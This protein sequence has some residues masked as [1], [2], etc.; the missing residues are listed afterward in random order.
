LSGIAACFPSVG[1]QWPDAA[2]LS[3]C[4]CSPPDGGSA[5]DEEVG[6]VPVQGTA[7]IVEAQRDDSL[8]AKSKFDQQAQIDAIQNMVDTL[9]TA[10]AGG[11]ANPWSVLL[12]TADPCTRIGLKVNCLSSKLPTSAP[13][14]RAIIR[15][16]QNN[17]GI[18][19]S[20]IVVWDRTF[21]EL[22]YGKYTADVLQ[23]AQ[24][25]GTLGQSHGIVG[26]GYSDTNH[27][28]FDGFDSDAKLAG[29]FA[30][31]LSRILTDRTDITINCPVLKRHGVSGVTA[32]MKN[33]YGMFDIP[34][35]FH[36]P[37]L[38]TVLPAIYSIPQIRN[39]IKLTIV[40]ALRSE[41]LRDTQDPPDCAPKRVFAS[42][43]PV[44]IDCYAL[45]L[46]NQLRAILNAPPISGPEVG[47]IDN[48]Y[49]LGLG[50]KDYNLV[51][52]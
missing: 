11:A 46:L 36:S 43:D 39:S 33:I 41:T 24:L 35:H 3:T 38:Q 6:L 5:L 40:D 17:L 2:V 16:L 37:Y 15:N 34:G 21:T 29:K 49:Q 26:P 48:A 52:V 1:G 7:T 44:A 28:A 22:G 13:V 23:G 51:Q 19:P 50:T 18:C 14:V 45:T 12:P 27:G 42:L 25:L 10:L 8:D 20:N 47:W 31:R 30:P 4:G 9:L 32:S